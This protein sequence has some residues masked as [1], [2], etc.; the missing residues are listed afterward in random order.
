M[1]TDQEQNQIRALK[2]RALKLFAY[3][4]RLEVE[5]MPEDI[6]LHCKRGIL[7]GGALSS[8][9]HDE[10]PNDLDIYFHRH[11]DIVWANL[12]FKEQAN[13]RFIMDMKHNYMQAVVQ[14][15]YFTANAITLVN[16]LQLILLQTAELRN[17]FDFVHCMP[18]VDLNTNKLHISD[19]Q[20]QSIKNKELILNPNG[21]RPTQNRIEKYMGRGWKM[22]AEVARQYKEQQD[23][24]NRQAA[25]PLF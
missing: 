13:T 25:Q 11:E 12:F 16:G 6:Y 17:L 21:H 7:T 22:S 2:D 10:T 19:A 18:Y 3:K 8:L 9:F 14:G 24:N 23:I 20:F 1:F 15:K 4:A 5:G